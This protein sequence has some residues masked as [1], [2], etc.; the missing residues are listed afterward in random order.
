MKIKILTIFS[1]FTFLVFT[2]CGSDEEDDYEYEIKDRVEQYNDVERDSIMNY[3][4]THYY[5]LDD[6]FN[7]TIDTIDPAGS[8]VSIWEDPNLQVLQVPDPEVEDL[9][10]D[11]YYI[12]FREGENKQIE[13]FDNVL[14]SYKGW[15]LDDSV[16]DERIDKFP[17]WFSLAKVDLTYYVIQAFREVIP[18]FKDGTY[19]DNG[20]GTFTFDGYGAG[21]LITPSGLGYYN[22]VQT[23]IPEYSP[24]VFSFKTFVVDDDLD[25]DT[26]KNSDEDVDGDGDVNNDDTDED[27][28]KNIYDED[29]DNDGVLTK[30]EDANGDGDPTNDDSDGDGI[31]NYLDEDT[32]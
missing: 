18:M 12:P 15:L 10:Y 20:D 8:H 21:M 1:I 11:L 6:N 3:M 19:T 27:L 7:V 17:V 16:F 29:D 30:D 23:D 13:K 4:Q 5:T 31:P 22:V 9:I 28:V 24:L 26:V 25:N 14:I 32:H 2:S